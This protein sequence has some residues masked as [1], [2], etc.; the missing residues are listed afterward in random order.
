MEY[1]V[2]RYLQQRERNPETQEL[3][4]EAERSSRLVEDRSSLDLPQPLPRMPQCEHPVPWYEE[5]HCFQDWS[6]LESMNGF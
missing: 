1:S 4:P 3:E 2:G 5:P 6:P